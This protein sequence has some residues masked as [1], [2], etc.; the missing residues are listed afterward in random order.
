VTVCDALAHDLA[1][2]RPQHVR[3]TSDATIF[4]KPGLQEFPAS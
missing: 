2:V 1:Q 3:I 4:E